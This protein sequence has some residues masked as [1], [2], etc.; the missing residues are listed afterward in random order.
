MLEPSV[1]ESDRS[2]TPSCEDEVWEGLDTMKDKILER[3]VASDSWVELVQKRQDHLLK[4]QIRQGITVVSQ[5]AEQ[6]SCIER[7]GS[8]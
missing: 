7:H 1:A 2:S 3:L 6:R 8:A 5:G 4:N